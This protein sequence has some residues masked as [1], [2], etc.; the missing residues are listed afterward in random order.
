MNQVQ[1]GKRKEQ[2]AAF[3]LAGQGMRVLFS[4]FRIGQG[5]IDIIGIHEDCLVFV[6]VKYRRNERAGMPEDAVGVGKQRKI[7]RVSDYF[8]LTHRQYEGLQVR[9]D[10]VAIMGD[11]I[12]WYKNAFDY[13]GEGQGNY[14]RPGF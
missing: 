10:V 7:C 11:E 4:N 9:Y 14:G 1:E 13:Q 8:R 12:R 6:E 5:E 2:K 3:Y